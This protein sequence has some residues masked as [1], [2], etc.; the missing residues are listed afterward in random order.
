MKFTSVLF[1]VFVILVGYLANVESVTGE[2]I[3]CP[4]CKL[5]KLP[6]VRKFFKDVS[7]KVLFSFFMSCLLQSGQADSY[8]NLKI[9]F[10]QGRNPDLLV[11]D[12]S[13][14]LIERI[15]LSRVC[16]LLIIAL[17]CVKFYVDEKC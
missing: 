10:I 3:S 8:N 17:I 13:G 1:I 16:Y 2:I 7:H 9:T 12:D 14:N 6:E 4:G 11:K 5:N 15:D